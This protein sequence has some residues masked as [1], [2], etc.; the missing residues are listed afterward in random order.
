MNPWNSFLQTVFQFVKSLFTGVTK[1]MH[2]N[3]AILTMGATLIAVIPFTAVDFQGGGKNAIV[4]FAETQGGSDEDS[5]EETE[6]TALPE[7]DGN[8]LEDETTADETSSSAENEADIETET[9]TETQTETETETE[10]TEMND[11]KE[12]TGIS[13]VEPETGS[14]ETG[15]QAAAETAM[16]QEEP[17]RE[18][19]TGY[20]ESDY[21]VLLRIVQA[22]AGN[23]DIEGRVMVA[24][25]I[26]NRVESGSFPNT[27][28]KVVY[29]K[30]QFS[31]VSNGSIKRCKVTTET[32]E[33]VER[34]LAGEDLT[35]G[36]LY[37]MNRRASSKKNANW[38]DR[39]LEFLF[40]HGN[41]EFFR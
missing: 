32:V 15:V 37:F 36:A 28:T 27:I 22:E 29:Q 12:E 5:L 24:N 39:H 1:K 19:F 7:T 21:N 40:K 41:H 6:D 25:V 16:E 13:E 9:E 35:D 14:E 20:S 23:C 3:A 2:R 30:H 34:A 11:A 4:A 10:N 17:V 38:F 18:V 33:A 26:L 31:P 8:V